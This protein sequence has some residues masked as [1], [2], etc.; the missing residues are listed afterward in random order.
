[1]SR[2][3]RRG[4]REAADMVFVKKRRAS[5]HAKALRNGLGLS[6]TPHIPAN[7]MLHSEKS[8]L[9]QLSKAPKQNSRNRK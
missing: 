2:R 1:M 6:T 5:S 8:N 7:V 4:K 3:R 9:L